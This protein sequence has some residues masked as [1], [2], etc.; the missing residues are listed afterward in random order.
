MTEKDQS[1]ENIHD[2][3]AARVKAEAEALEGEKKDDPITQSFVRDCLNANE[4]GDGA[5]FAALHRGKFIYNKT[6]GAWFA[7]RGHYWD[8]D[9]MGESQRAVEE[10]AVR[11]LTAADELTEK[12]VDAR[13]N[14]KKDLARGLKSQQEDYKKRVKRL[15]SVSGA[16]NCLNWGHHVEGA[17]SIRGE[18]FD[19]NPWLLAC[20][21]GVIELN[22]GRFRD[23]RPGDSLT[24][25][26]LHDWQG[27]DQPAVNWEKFLNDVFGGDQELISYLQRVFGYAL[28]GAVKEHIF[29]VLHGE[30]RNGKSTLIET[31]KYVLG[32]LAQ[33]IP[34]ELLLDQKNA[35]SSAAPSPDIM[36][37]KGL[38][39][40][41]ASETDDNRRFSATQVKRLSGGDYLTGR[42]PHD[43]YATTFEPTHLLCLLT[44]HLPH[45]A[46]DDFAFWQRLHLVPFK[47]KFVDHP[48]GENELPRDKELTEKL[49]AEAPGILAWMVRG[50][51]EWQ[52]Q[53]INPP[54]SVRAATEQ[55]RFNED[56]LAEF[57]EARCYAP[58]ETKDDRTQFKDLYEAFAEWYEAHIGDAKYCPK[59]KKFSQLVEKRFKKEK[60]GGVIWFYGLSLMPK[61]EI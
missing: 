37:L 56:V 48:K 25:A 45:A 60:A 16:Q 49:K 30:G 29:L 7:W 23:G 40:A 43:K 33:P 36:A 32:D 11:Y 53:G 28:I 6:S 20:R 15:R 39:L 14:D 1:L 61:T 41:F 21:N 58:E 50:C 47:Y 34:G 26:A 55:Y 31:L 27:E 42:N 46:G 57:I 9:V 13:K 18:E 12:I 54:L 5:L 22:T 19:R 38:R 51:I 2:E 52:R 24:K 59:K 8:F 10:V 4:R 17:L 44:N 3:V 35:R